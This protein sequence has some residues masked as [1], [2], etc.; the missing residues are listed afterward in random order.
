MKFQFFLLFS[1]FCCPFFYFFGS[2]LQ[3]N[4]CLSIKRR[5]FT[6]RDNRRTRDFKHKKDE[7]KNSRE[8]RMV[9]FSNLFM[10]KYENE[11]K[12]K[13]NETW[14]KPW[15]RLT[16]KQWD[17]V[18]HAPPFL[19]SFAFSIPLPPSTHL[20]V[21]RYDPF[22][23]LCSCSISFP[24]HWGLA[25]LMIGLKSACFHCGWRNKMFH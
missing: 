24:K 19:G 16:W 20:F 25:F 17:W 15:E 2:N 13:K 5:K 3:L 10:L 1:F 18:G 11:R 12:K 22:C 21:S 8:I 9:G 23:V 6:R 14:G 7:N 4:F